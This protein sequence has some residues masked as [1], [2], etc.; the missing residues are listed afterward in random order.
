[1]DTLSAFAPK[2]RVHELEDGLRN[3]FVTAME[4]SKL[5]RRQRACWTIRSP[6][7]LGGKS[8]RLS[9]GDENPQVFDPCWMEDNDSTGNEYDELEDEDPANDARKVVEIVVAPGLFKRG[10][11]DGENYD[12]ETCIVQALVQCK[13]W[14]PKPRRQRSRSPSGLLN[15]TLGMVADKLGF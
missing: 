11:A 10:D 7:L 1:M 6:N 4:F 12:T 2:E 13:T 14:S 5:I 15:R 9:T 8:R 3:V